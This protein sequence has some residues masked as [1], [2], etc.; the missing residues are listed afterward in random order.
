M[1]LPLESKK[2]NHLKQIETREVRY[3]DLMNECQENREN[4]N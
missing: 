3:F 1:N 4:C 2:N